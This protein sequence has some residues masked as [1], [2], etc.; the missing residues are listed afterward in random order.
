MPDAPTIAPANIGGAQPPTFAE[1]ARLWARIGL[2]NFGGPA[3]QIALMHRT[4]VDE[5]KWIDEGRY[6]SALN[7]CMLLPGP[8]AMQLAT[9]VGWRLHGL[10]GGLTAGLLFVAPG[11]V[12][13]LVL[14]AL[15]AA[16]GKL[17]LAEALF[18]GVKA[19]V[20][21]IVVEALL[22]IARR[23]LKGQADWLVAAAA[24]IGIFLLRVPFPLIVISAALVGFW[25]GGRVIDAPLASAQPASVTVGQTLRTVAIWLAIWIVPLAVVR[26]LF[27]PGH[28]LSEIGWFFFQACRHDLRGRL[29]GPRLHGAGRGGALPL[30]ARGRDAGRSRAGGDHSRSS[31]LVTEFVGFLA[32]FREG[33]G[34]AW[35]M[36]VL[37]A[38]VTLWATFAPCF[39]WIFAGAPYIERLNAEPR[40][41]AALA[42]VTAAVVGVILNL[43]VW[44]AL[45][46]LFGRVG[47]W[48]IGLLHVST[49]DPATLNLN[50]LA[51]SLLAAVLLFALHRGVLTT[52]A[53]C[54]AAAV[55]AFMMGL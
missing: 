2:I 33:G 32:A 9:Y 8:E 48:R 6:L 30:A 23:A 29:C 25:S 12:V 26:F 16:F 49:P 27:G 1:A 28:V 13:V 55:A 50:A 38:L 39:L 24:F 11:A 36:G 54:S 42:A 44:F 45:Q 34:N 21:A 3:G 19:A 53:I 52:L 5:K 41:K 46:V 37:G 15:Y 4:L 40:L 51:L 35:A 43:T 20:L 10:K 31:D 18:L 7:F 14:S 47:E 22:R 17:P